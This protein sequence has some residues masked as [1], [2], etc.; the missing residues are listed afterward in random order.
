MSNN[1]PGI[2]ENKKDKIRAI[3]LGLGAAISVFF[4]FYALDQR[5]E[6]LN[7]KQQLEECQSTI[8]TDN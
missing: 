4:F 7:L 3:L 2:L 5:S 8:P 6:V 1:P